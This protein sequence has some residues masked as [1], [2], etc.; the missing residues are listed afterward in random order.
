MRLWGTIGGCDGG[1]GGGTIGLVGKMV[2][3]DKG[4]KYVHSKRNTV[5]TRFTIRAECWLKSTDVVKRL[6]QLCVERDQKPEAFELNPG[7][8]D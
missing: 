2:G 4:G 7:I 3:K 1:G 8:V 6:A 5:T